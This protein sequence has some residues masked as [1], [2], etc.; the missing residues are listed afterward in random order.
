MRA[1]STMPE[2]T[3]SRTRHVSERLAVRILPDS[4]RGL[5]QMATRVIE[6]PITHIL[7]DLGRVWG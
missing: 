1:K 6:H 2:D 4:E 5:R 7:P 3:G